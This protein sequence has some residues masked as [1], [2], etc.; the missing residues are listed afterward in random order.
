[1][2]FTANSSGGKYNHTHQYGTRNTDYYGMM[3]SVYLLSND[4]EYKGGTKS[5]LKRNGLSVPSAVNGSKT[6]NNV[7]QWE[8]KANVSNT[9]LV[10]PYKGVYY[11]R[12]TA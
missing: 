10:Q 6:V 7:D 1:M 3:S 9:S 12:R 8:T 11:W 5:S 2:T 4:G